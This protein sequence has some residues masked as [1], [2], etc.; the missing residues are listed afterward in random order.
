M[1]G[2]EM[3]ERLGRRSA[4]GTSPDAAYTGYGYEEARERSGGGF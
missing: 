1:D 4:V 3:A 2:Y